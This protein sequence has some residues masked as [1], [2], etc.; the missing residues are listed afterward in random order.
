MDVTHV[1]LKL[2]MDSDRVVESIG[3]NE[4]TNKI[5]LILPQ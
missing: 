4:M 5:D 2:T 1:K 3:A